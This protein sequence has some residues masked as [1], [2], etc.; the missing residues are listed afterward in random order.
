ME[1][2]IGIATTILG[3]A[4]SQIVQHWESWYQTACRSDLRGEWI[5]LDCYDHNDFF[6]ER[7]TIS[8]KR[9]RLY[10]RNYGA[11]KTGQLYE[12]YCTVEDHGVLTGTWRSLRPGA[13]NKGR[14]LVIINPQA[15]ILTG[16][17]SGKSDDGRELLF[18]WVLARDKESL[19]K[20]ATQSTIT[21]PIRDVGDEHAQL[22]G[23]QM[24]KRGTTRS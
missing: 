13:T 7:V 5:A 3:I 12:A 8:R 20:A 6:L 16:V 22:H 1:I 21:F 10:I 4:L 18:Y 19:Q 23:S 24:S 11:N 15:T 9:G 14:I 17:Y 2:L